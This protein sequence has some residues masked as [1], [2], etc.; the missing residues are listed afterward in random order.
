MSAPRVI[1]IGLDGATWRI[2]KPWA[3]AGELPNLKRVVEGGATGLLES[4][5]PPLTPTG[6]TSAATGKTPGRHN[7]YSF[8]RPMRAS[9]RRQ[10][11]N[12]R[13]CRAAKIW[14]I[15]NAYGRKAGV[16]SAALL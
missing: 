2:L 8:F 12:S 10:V 5:L 7:V 9:Y 1:M 11:L 14:Q 4:T 13:D 15:A 3:L 6:W 16:V